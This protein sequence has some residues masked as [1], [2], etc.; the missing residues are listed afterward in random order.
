VH[1]SS[2]TVG[3]RLHGLSIRK[4][5]I[6]VKEIVHFLQDLLDTLAQKPCIWRVTV[7]FG[8]HLAASLH[9]AATPKIALTSPPPTR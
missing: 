2:G 3:G 5:P 9:L 4:G 7:H 1:G 8:A 6:R